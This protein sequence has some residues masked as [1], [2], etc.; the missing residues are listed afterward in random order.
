MVL[1]DLGSDLEPRIHGSV[2]RLWLT[3]CLYP[4]FEDDDGVA[5]VSTQLH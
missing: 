1:E 3:Y 2:G 4:L 5:L